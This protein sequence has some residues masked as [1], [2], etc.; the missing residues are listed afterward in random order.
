MGPGRETP[1]GGRVAHGRRWVL[2]AAVTSVLTA[3]SMG[4]SVVAG[5]SAGRTHG[6]ASVPPADARATFT[7]HGSIGQAYCS[8]G[9]PAPLSL[10]VDAVGAP[11]GE[12]DS[13]RPGE[14]DHPGRGPG[15]AT[16]SGPVAGQSVDG[17]GAFSGA[18]DRT[19]RP[20]APSTPTSTWS[21]G[22]NYITMRDGVKLAAT[23]RLPTGK[24]LAD[25]PFPTVIEESGYA[26]RRPAQPHRRRAPPE[27]RVHVGPTGPRHRPPRRLADRPPA[28]VRHGQPADA[29]DR[30]LGRVRS[31]SSTCPPPTTATTPC[32]SPPRSPGL[33]TTRSAWWGSRSRASPRCSSPGPSPPGLAADRPDEPH[34]RPLHNRLPRRHVQ[35]RLRRHLAR[36][37]GGRR[38]AGAAGRPEYAKVLIQQGDTAV[39]GQPGSAR[40]DPERRRPARRGQPP[41]A[42]PLHTAG[43]RHL[44]AEGRRCRSSLSGAFQ[45]E[46]TGRPV[47]G[48]HRRP[49]PDPY[50]WATIVNGTHID[51]LGP[52]TITRWL[53]FLDIFVADKVPTAVAGAHCPRPRALPGLAD[54]PSAPLPAIRFT[55]EPNV[56]RRP[57]RTSK[58]SPRV[59][60]LFDNG[61]GSA[62]AG[63]TPAGLE[64][65]LHVVAATPARATTCHLGSG[66][67]LA[68]SQTG[69]GA[70]SFQP[71]PSARP[72]I[73]LASERNAWAALPPYDWAP[74]TGEPG[75]GSSPRRSPSDLVVVG[76]GQPR[77]LGREHGSRH[78]PAGHGLRGAPRQARNCSCRPA[79]LRA[80][81]R[82]LDPSA[83]DGHPSGPTYLASTATPL[84]GGQ[85]HRWSGSRSSPSATPSGP[86]HGSGSDRHRARG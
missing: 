79:S 23:V 51:S 61:G 5:A 77:P 17:H 73:D 30:M 83:L 50:V 19:T 12:R 37:A 7:G 42:F 47:A 53:E 84:P 72:A 26:D 80:S 82:A 67:T 58:S 85:V 25:G 45:D 54:A 10:L 8:V 49:G 14:P 33:P 76:P 48:H 71:D 43:P 35:Q 55:N 13:R 20:E 57:G 38:Q 22:L 36:R 70:V 11:G 3:A 46:Q 31:T 69:A 65:G 32:R 44:G 56:G 41:R 59:R 39:P 2:L 64:R 1:K 74:V 6:L 28:R 78:R 52:G 21:A 34:R 62:G 81:D 29:G 86:D 18:V 16:R 68:R 40:T 15:P 66:G 60:V 27:R 9:R 63:A 4:W 24:T 75:S